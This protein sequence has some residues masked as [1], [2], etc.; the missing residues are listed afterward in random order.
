MRIGGR[1]TDGGATKY[2]LQA[3]DSISKPVVDP[4]SQGGAKPKGAP[5]YY[6]AKVGETLHDPPLITGKKKE[7]ALLLVKLKFTKLI[8]LVVSYRVKNMKDGGCCNS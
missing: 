3:T 4:D 7:F 6:L 8:K 2:K 1:P 5:T